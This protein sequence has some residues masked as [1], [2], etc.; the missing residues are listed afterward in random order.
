MCRV[1]CGESETR[2]RRP[3][4]AE[5]VSSTIFPFSRSPV[6]S[7][8]TPAEGMQDRQRRDQVPAR[9]NPSFKGTSRLETE[10][11]S[12]SRGPSC[13]PPRPGWRSLLGTRDSS[14]SLLSGATG[15]PAR[16]L[17]TSWRGC[18]RQGPAPSNT[19]STCAPTSPRG[20]PPTRTLTHSTGAGARTPQPHQP[21][22]GPR[23]AWGSSPAEAARRARAQ[24]GWWCPQGAVG[25][26]R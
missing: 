19:L 9:S 10:P 14:T 16:T 24:A 17:G 4:G 6:H 25:M 2:G 15:E 3:G 13:G 1:P 22:L 21:G 8:S 20:H 5:G 12:D 7:P 23:G 11:K 26:S 18:P